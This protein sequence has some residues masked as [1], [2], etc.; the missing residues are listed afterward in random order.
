LAVHLYGLEALR[1]EF[2][3]LLA[4]LCPDL[5]SILEDEETHVWFFEREIQKIPAGEE[6][7]AQ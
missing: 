3:K 7:F 5:S 1:L 4:G 2:A 6:V